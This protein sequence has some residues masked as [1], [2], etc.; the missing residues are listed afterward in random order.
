MSTVYCTT[1]ITCIVG[2]SGITC[3]PANAS[4]SFRSHDSPR[5]IHFRLTNSLAVHARRYSFRI[6]RVVVVSSDVVTFRVR[7]NMIRTKR[8][9]TFGRLGV[10]GPREIMTVT[11]CHDNKITGNFVSS[12]TRTILGWSLLYGGPN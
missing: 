11:L 9:V 8:F 5:Q 12:G 10:F 4:R 3:L 6:I 2:H 7:R 1:R